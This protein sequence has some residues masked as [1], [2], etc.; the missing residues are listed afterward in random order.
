MRPLPEVTPLDGDVDMARMALNVAKEM[1]EK[2]KKA[3]RDRL[4][5]DESDNVVDDHDDF[6]YSLDEVRFERIFFNLLF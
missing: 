2:R 4:I 3:A 6:V 5:K 1:E